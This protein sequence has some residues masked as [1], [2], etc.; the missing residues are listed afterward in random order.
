MPPLG[1]AKGH[2]MAPPGEKLK[3]SISHSFCNRSIHCVNFSH[4]MLKNIFHI[5]I[6]Q[7]NPIQS[8]AM[9]DEI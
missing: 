9:Y 2:T 7:S 3:I 4:C 5:I 6:S 8:N 1:L